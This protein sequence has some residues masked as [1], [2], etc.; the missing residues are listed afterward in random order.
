M[1][2]LGVVVAVALLVFLGGC[3]SFSGS[4]GDRVVVGKC[5]VGGELRTNNGGASVRLG[6]KCFQVTKDAVT[7]D[8]NGVVQLPANW[9]QLELDESL[10]AV[11]I[12]VDGRRLAEIKE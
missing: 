1:K 4:F 10:G 2:I 3:G 7:W 8:Q 11:A 9:S 6:G 5:L 12:N